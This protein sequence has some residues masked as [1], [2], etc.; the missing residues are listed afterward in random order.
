MIYQ[1]SPTWVEAVALLWTTKWKLAWMDY[2]GSE[3]LQ[4]RSCIWLPRCFLKT[5]SRLN[6]YSCVCCVRLVY[7]VNALHFSFVTVGERGI[8]DITVSEMLCMKNG[9]N[10][11]SPFKVGRR[12]AA[13]LSCV[14][15]GTVRE[16]HTCAFVVPPT[17]DFFERSYK[18][19][20]RE[21]FDLLASVLISQ[22]RL[23]GSP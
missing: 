23:I 18:Q 22:L 4:T 21:Q 10:Y 12:T 11:S 17:R 15:T 6:D 1:L 5:L 7:R 9:L 13:T 2:R 16:G 8:A 20:L 3:R 14:G 19:R